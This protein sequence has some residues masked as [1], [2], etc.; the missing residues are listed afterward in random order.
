MHMK[1]IISIL[2]I[3]L[4]ITSCKEDPKKELVGTWKFEGSVINRYLKDTTNQI[5]YFQFADSTDVYNLMGILS[6]DK[7]YTKGYNVDWTFYHMNFDSLKL[8]YNLIS[9]DKLEVTY[10]DSTKNVYSRIAKDIR[11]NKLFFDLFNTFCQNSYMS[12]DSLGDG[13]LW[14]KFSL[15]EAGNKS[16]SAFEKQVKFYVDKHT[17][18]LP[19]KEKTDEYDRMFNRM[20]NTYTWED[21]TSK[22]LMECSFNYKNLK[23]NYTFNDNDE[24]EVK[25]WLNVK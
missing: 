22:I 20:V 15:Y 18:S 13:T 11:P 4:F 5:S 24:L 8:E 16:I 9:N 6:I 14:C 7:M 23:D 10:S 3:V 25:I 19:K 12:L 21:L 1:S 2:L 17:G